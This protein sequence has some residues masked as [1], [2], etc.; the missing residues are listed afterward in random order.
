[1]GAWFSCAYWCLDQQTGRR[2]NNR[3]NA[4]GQVATITGNT[5]YGVL[6][7]NEVFFGSRSPGSQTCKLSIRSWRDS[8]L[9]QSS[10]TGAKP[11]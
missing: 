8:K 3:K 1:M 11:S 10:E 5:M 9:K 2:R 4:G 7:G 6:F